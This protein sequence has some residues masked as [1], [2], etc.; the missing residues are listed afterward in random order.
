MAISAITVRLH[1]AV[2][3]DITEVQITAPGAATP[4]VIATTTSR[5]WTHDL[6]VPDGS[7]TIAVTAV[8]P[9]RQETRAITVRGP[10]AGLTAAG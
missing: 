2:A 10:G 4:T 8:G 9:T 6:A 3:P 5:A 1:G 7:V